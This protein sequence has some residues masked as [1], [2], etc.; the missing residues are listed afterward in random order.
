MLYF[1]ESIYLLEVACNLQKHFLGGKLMK[2]L[3]LYAFIFDKKVTFVIKD[4][5]VFEEQRIIDYDE[6]YIMTEDG[7][8]SWK[9]I[10]KV[11]S[12]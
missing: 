6:G 1:E 5:R 7:R 8:I 11:I 12:I 9:D 3:I 2:E 4:G 10:S